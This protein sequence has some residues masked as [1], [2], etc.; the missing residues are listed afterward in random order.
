MFPFVMMLALTAQFA[1]SE[2]TV[3]HRAEC[4]FSPQEQGKTQ[5]K[6]AAKPLSLPAGGKWKSLFDGK[7][8]A[9]WKRTEFGGGGDVK[10][11]PKFRD[12]LPAVK[13]ESGA[14]LSGFNW[15]GNALP[16]TNYEIALE[17]MKLD[18]SD[19]FCGLTFPVE[20]SHASLILGGW[21]GG[22]VGI[23]SIDNRDAS[24]N[25]TTRHIP[26]AKNQ[27]FKIR[28]R[29]TPA[30]IEVWLDTKQIVDQEITGKKISL[31]P[32]EITNSVPL[33]ISTYQTTGVFRSIKLRRIDS[34]TAK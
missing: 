33:G 30:K 8:L 28:V 29:V 4:S 27:W 13:V 14:A 20:D 10:I 7:S 15:T 21:G 5:S 24:E 11:E 17:A 22:T 6:D 12:G 1:L 19:F 31:R 32:G 25:D 3:M 18:G 2:P 16:N 9:G 26:F 23:S 34:K